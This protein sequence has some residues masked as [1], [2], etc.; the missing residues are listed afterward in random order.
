MGDHSAAMSLVVG[1]LAALQLFQPTLNFGI[2]YT[3]FSH[4]RP[5]HTNAVI[6][7]FVGNGMFMAIY[8]SLQRLCKARMYSDLLSRITTLV[9]LVSGG[10]LL[11]GAGA[12]LF[13]AVRIDEIKASFKRD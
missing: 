7:A 3:T 8:Y 9:V 4:I 11:Y 1:L 13:G 5:L 10:V 2:S 12:L 6:F